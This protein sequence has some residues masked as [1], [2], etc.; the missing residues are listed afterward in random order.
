MASRSVVLTHTVD[1]QRSTA[2]YLPDNVKGVLAHVPALGAVG[3]KAYFE[4]YTAEPPS[5]ADPSNAVLA[6][7][8]DVGWTQINT[9]L[10]TGGGEVSVVPATWPIGGCWCRFFVDTAQ[11]A[12]RSFRVLFPE[13]G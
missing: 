10:S 4:V 6:A 1:T 8:N 12:T 7:T 13:R 5:P 2:F 11:G 3:H 9:A